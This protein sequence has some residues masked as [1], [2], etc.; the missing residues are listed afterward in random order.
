M[1]ATLDLDLVCEHTPRKKIKLDISYAMP[2][3]SSYKSH[4]YGVADPERK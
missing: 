1:R 4:P 2:H 3:N